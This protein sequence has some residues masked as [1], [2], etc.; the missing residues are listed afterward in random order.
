L[1]GG[2]AHEISNPLTYVVD[3]LAF[4]KTVLNGTSQPEASD[5]SE[6]QRAVCE[7]EGGVARIRT[8][9]KDLKGFARKGREEAGPVDIQAVLESTL[10]I[11]SGETHKTARVVRKYQNIPFA[12]ANASRLGQVFLNLLLNA[13][14]AFSAKHARNEIAVLTR[15]ENGRVYAE[16]A[17][18]GCGIPPENLGKIFEPYF[19]TKPEG[20]GTGLGL[21]ICRELVMAHGGD[22]QVRSET[23][24]GACFTVSLPVADSRWAPS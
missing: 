7:T 8:L 21:P 16:I 11:A 10:N 6:I 18:N 4:L 1:V 12:H 20:I 22:I 15:Y 13:A 3:N 5:L 2:V 9:V 24:V 17:D 23:G 14:Q 19:T